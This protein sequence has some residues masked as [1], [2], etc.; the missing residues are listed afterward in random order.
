MRWAGF[1]S[2]LAEDV[3]HIYM[4]LSLKLPRTAPLVLGILESDDHNLSIGQQQI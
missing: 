4:L 1:G 2:V 3:D